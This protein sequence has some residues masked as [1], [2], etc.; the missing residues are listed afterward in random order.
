MLVLNAFSINM[1]D[2]PESLV[3]FTKMSE[4]EA[5]NLAHQ[6]PIVSAVGHSS[7]AGIFTRLLG[8]NIP[9]N[10]VTISLRPGQVALVGQYRGPRLEEFAT[11]LPEGSAIDWLMIEVLEEG[12]ES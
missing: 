11:E 5:K 6:E 9:A 8:T 12:E 4:R 3:R 7:T 1:L 2:G 10:R